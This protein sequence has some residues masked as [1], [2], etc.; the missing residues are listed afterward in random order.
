M[1]VGI[2]AGAVMLI[3][4]AALLLFFVVMPAISQNGAPGNAT[5]PQQESPAAMPPPATTTPE[6]EPTPTT[7]TVPEP[8]DT[9]IA[10]ASPVNVTYLATAQASSTLKPDTNPY[11]PEYAIDGSKA[12]C[13]AE[14]VS[15]YGIGSTLTFNLDEPVVLSELKV[16]PGFDKTAQGWSRW[17]ANGRLKKVVITTDTGESVTHTF[18]DSKSWQSVAFTSAQPASRITITIKSV[19]KAKKVKGHGPYKDTSVSEVQIFGSPTSD[20]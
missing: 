13:W 12:T 2:I 17:A 14:G 1:I 5:D 10:N 11:Y 9:E 8:D 7:P 18:K 3:I 4:A 15:G 20:Y 6:P 19:Y 16:V